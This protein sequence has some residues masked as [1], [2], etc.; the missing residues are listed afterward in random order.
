MVN[1]EAELE[2]VV[3]PDPALAIELSASKPGFVSTALMSCY[4]TLEAPALVSNGSVFEQGSDGQWYTRYLLEVT[5]RDVYP[6]EMFTPAPD[7]PPC[8]LNTESSRTWVDI[9]DDQGQRR[10]GFCALTSSDG[11]ENLWFS[12][13]QGAPAPQGAYVEIED[14][15]C[16]NT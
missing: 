13:P 16:G 15:A 14:R 9:F 12:V 1:G 5:N 8:G 2:Y 11:L 4:P 7:L 3:W 6:D 10:Y